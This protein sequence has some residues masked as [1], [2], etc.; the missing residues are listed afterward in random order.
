M[1][2]IFQYGCHTGLIDEMLAD[3]YSM[4]IRTKTRQTTRLGVTKEDSRTPT[5][6]SLWVV[7]PGPLHLSVE[8]LALPTSASS[9]HTAPPPEQ[10]T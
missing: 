9:T 6:I 5:R 2:S 3:R 1:W 10:S 4:R 7:I 8:T